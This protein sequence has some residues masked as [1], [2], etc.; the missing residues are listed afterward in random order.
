VI[1]PLRVLIVMPLATPLGGGEQSLRQLLKH[2]RD[3]GITWRVVYLRGGPMVD[4]TR[5]LGIDADVL[6]AGRLREIGKRFDAIRRV[7]AMARAWRADCIFGWMVAG[8]LTA[9]AAGVLSG[10]PVVW[11]QVGLPRPDWLDRAATALPARGVLV[12]SR[13]CGEAQARVWPHRAQQLVYP[14]ASLDAFNP[15]ALPTPHDARTALGLSSAGPLVGIVA[16][17]Q[18]WKGVHVFVDAVAIAAKRHPGLHAVVVGGAH[19]TEP[20]YR[21]ELEARARQLG[22]E[23]RITFAGFQ[24]NVPVWMQ[25]MDIVVHASD[26]EP[27]GMVVVEAMALGKPVIAG[28]SGGPAEIITDGVDGV[29]APFGDTLALGGA[30]SRLIDDPAL[31]RRLGTAARARAAAF[32]ERAFAQH[33]ITALRSFLGTP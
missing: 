10:I 7:A 33:V 29:L 21:E 18:R 22:I 2:G 14:G 15:E 20:G 6:D 8:Q 27:F 16:R 1:A 28:Q 4:E 3:A 17:L 30:I 32:D 31:A 24:S 19:E 23:S 9:G 12:N 26:R 5:D 25:A 11:S 13:A